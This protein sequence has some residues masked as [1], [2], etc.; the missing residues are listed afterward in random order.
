VKFCLLAI[1][2]S[3]GLFILS[4]MLNWIAAWHFYYPFLALVSSACAAAILW[5]SSRWQGENHHGQ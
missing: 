5:L 3:L 1:L 2:V 4:A